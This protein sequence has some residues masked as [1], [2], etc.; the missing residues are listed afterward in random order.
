M[1]RPLLLIRLDTLHYACRYGYEKIVEYLTVELPEVVMGVDQPSLLCLTCKCGHSNIVL[2]LMDKWR[3][4][5]EKRS[6]PVIEATLTKLLLAA[7]QYDDHQVVHYL[8]KRVA[9]SQNIKRSSVQAKEL[10][11]SCCKNGLLDVLKQLRLEEWCDLYAVDKFGKLGIHYACH[12]GHYAIVKHLVEN[13]SCDINSCDRD[14]LTPL[15]LACKY[16]NNVDVVEYILS[17]PECSVFV[18]A[19]NIDG[20]TAL[21]FAC[22]TDEFNPQILNIL[23][24]N[25]ASVSN[26]TLSSIQQLQNA[27]NDSS[28]KP[29]I[30]SCLLKTAKWDVNIRNYA[31]ITPVQL[32]TYPFILKEIISCHT[33][34][35]FYRLMECGSEYS[36]LNEIIFHI[37]THQLDLNQT[38]SNGDAALHIAYAAN[39][40]QIANYLLNHFNFTPN[41]NNKAGDTLILKLHINNPR[42]ANNTQLI[43]I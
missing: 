10:F 11:I 21:H 3:I 38:A 42:I 36:A 9:R 13:C 35:D 1:P 29:A 4:T 27:N 7:C 40:V 2:Y 20:N 24:E 22:I 16:G 14:G 8:L 28:T 34:T 18:K 6:E 41:V 15:H 33:E 19:S 37:E 25:G 43:L 39:K 32:A 30:V 23:V 17:W 26:E 12:K 5:P 31:G